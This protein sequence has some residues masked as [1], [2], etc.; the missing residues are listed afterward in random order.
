MNKTTIRLLILSQVFTLFFLIF[1][2]VLIRLLNDMWGR[3]LYTLLALGAIGMA[4]AL[5]YAL[6]GLDEK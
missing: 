3:V 2:P 4:L 1:M 6:N 5:R